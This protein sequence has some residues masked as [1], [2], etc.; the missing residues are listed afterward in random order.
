L[1]E[2]N[3]VTIREVAEQAQ[4]SHQTVSRVINNSERVSPETRGRVLAAIDELGYRPNAI[5]RIMAQG[6][7]RT[8]AC[9]SPNLT[10][11]TFASIIEGA[12]VEARQNGYFLLSASAPDEATFALLVE[13][14][15]ES[16]R[17]DGLLVINPYTD[18]RFRLVPRDVRMVY[19]G[20]QPRD[21]Q[22]DSVSIDDEGAGQSACQHLIDLGHRRIA[23]ITGPTCEDC[24]QDRSGG[25]R[26]SLLNA[27]LAPDPDLVIEGDWS[28]T[29]GY[30]AIRILVERQVYFSAVFAQNDRMAVGAIQALREAHLKVPQDVSIIGFD[31]MPLSSYFDPP[32]TTI[33]QDTFELGRRAAQLLLTAVE[34]PTLE[35]R[36]LLLPA[37]LVV[38]NSTSQYVERR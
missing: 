32:L 8:L 10:D 27:G 20:S 29:S 16:R 2:R 18:Q 14:L 23:T 37:E 17:T 21:E 30:N 38:R 4:V 1:T 26:Y 22:V 36:Q 12:E 31:D 5:A 34:D 15:I 33:R 6:R 13:Q 3:R 11:Y 7:T 28:A 25:Y 35:T 19:L 24:S 9:L